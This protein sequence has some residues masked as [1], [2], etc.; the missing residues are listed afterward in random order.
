MAHNNLRPFTTR[1]GHETRVQL[2]SACMLLLFWT[3]KGCGQGQ[4]DRTT[5]EPQM[6]GSL[7]QCILDLWLPTAASVK[8]TDRVARRNEGSAKCSSSRV[9]ATLQYYHCGDIEHLTKIAHLDGSR[10]SKRKQRFSLNRMRSNA[11]IM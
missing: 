10:N 4:S 2:P 9:H 1:Q 7:L 3:P 5:T 8:K 11:M 6:C